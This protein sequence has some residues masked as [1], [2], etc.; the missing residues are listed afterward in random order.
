[1]GDPWILKSAL[2][3]FSDPIWIAYISHCNEL[4]EAEKAKTLRQL[5]IMFDTASH[6]VR[7]NQSDEKWRIRYRLSRLEFNINKS[8]ISEGLNRAI[9]FVTVSG[10]GGLVAFIVRHDSCICDGAVEIEGATPQYTVLVYH[11]RP[12]NTPGIVASLHCPTEYG[13]PTH[14]QIIEGHYR[15]YWVAKITF[16]DLREIRM[17]P[18]PSE[19]HPVPKLAVEDVYPTLDTE[20]VGSDGQPRFTFP[21]YRKGGWHNFETPSYTETHWSDTINPSKLSG[22]TPENLGDMALKSLQERHAIDN[23]PVPKDNNWRLLENLHV[24]AYDKVAWRSRCPKPVKHYTVAELH[25]FGLPD[26]FIGWYWVARW[27]PTGA[28]FIVCLENDKNPLISLKRGE[29]V[30]VRRIAL[31][32][33]PYDGYMYKNIVAAPEVLI[34]RSRTLRIGVIWQHPGSGHAPVSSNVLFLYDFKMLYLGP[35]N[36]QFDKQQIIPSPGLRQSPRSRG[37]PTEW[38]VDLD[39]RYCG[40]TDMASL[41]IPYPLNDHN[42][43]LTS[44]GQNIE[45]LTKLAKKGP[46]T[47]MRVCTLGPKQGGLHWS[48]P[49]LTGG[50]EGLDWTLKEVALGGMRFQGD[51]QSEMRVWGP[52]STSPGVDTGAI[53]VDIFELG[54]GRMGTRC[55]DRIVG[56]RD[57]LWARFGFYDKACMCILHDSGYRITLPDV[58]DV[59]R[60]NRNAAARR[61]KPKSFVLLSIGKSDGSPLSPKPPKDEVKSWDSAPRREALRL[62]VE[63]REEYRLR[64]AREEVERKERILDRVRTGRLASGDADGAWEGQEGME[65][66]MAANGWERWRRKLVS[67]RG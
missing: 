19:Q 45:F 64:L 33:P 57:Q 52:S 55:Y 5:A 53:D 41:E 8:K 28:L 11:L 30:S 7:T 60:A 27:E 46:L 4:S 32:T 65:H 39:G 36:R 20:A 38:E 43:K 17:H 56:P 26:L 14:V 61:K 34:G 40:P 2:S 9:T 22:N 13:R 1:M 48:S 59:E 54:V 47:P 12:G 44:H 29:A 62:M 35:D 10:S 25:N 3:P 67:W 23:Y 21:G 50:D 51:G 15:V 24:D 49:L 42:V 66:V 18:P 16:A 63:R 31:L 6:P 37:F 58:A